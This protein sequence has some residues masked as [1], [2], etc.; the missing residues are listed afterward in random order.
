VDQAAA[1]IRI[2][3]AR[4][5]WRSTVAR[6]LDPAH[7]PLGA[8]QAAARPAA[9]AQPPTPPTTCPAGPPTTPVSQRPQAAR[10]AAERP[11]GARLTS[12]GDAR[13]AAWCGC[14]CHAALTQPSLAYRRCRFAS[15]RRCYLAGRAAGWMRPAPP[16]AAAWART[17]ASALLRQGSRC[18]H[19]PAGCVA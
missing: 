14:S 3:P 19:P 5:E 1:A 18:L 12:P 9:R 11:N 16:M 7:A 13:G 8:W 17:I 15:A 2:Q 6:C 10:T 4:A